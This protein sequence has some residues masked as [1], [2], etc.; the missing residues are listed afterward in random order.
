MVKLTENDFEYK[1]KKEIF[2]IL[3]IVVGLAPQT[4]LTFIFQFYDW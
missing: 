1:Q 3:R 2:G 4:N